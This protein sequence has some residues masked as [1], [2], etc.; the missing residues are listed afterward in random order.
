MA[1]CLSHDVMPKM[2]EHLPASDTDAISESIAL[3]D[4]ADLYIGV[5]AQRYGYVAEG[6]DSSI[7]E[8][9]YNRAIDRRIPCLIF[10]S[11]EEHLFRARDFDKGLSAQQLEQLRVLCPS[12]RKFLT[13]ATR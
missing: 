10:L 9:E 7:T 6:Y 8:M 5:F 13:G 12:P 4:G 1:A 11:H 3:V 2:M